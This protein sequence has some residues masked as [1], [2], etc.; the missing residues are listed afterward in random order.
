MKNI[1]FKTENLEF[2]G[3]IKYKDIEIKK[4]LINFIVGE[5]GVGKSTLFKLL[6]CSLPKS[7][8]NIYYNDIN[9]DNIDTLKLRQ[10]ISLISQDIFLFD[11]SIKYNFI[12]F[13]KYRKLPPPTDITIE[14]FLKLCCVYFNLDKDASTMSGG[15]RQRLY[16]A[17]FLSLKPKV[18]LLDEPT[19][20]L[21]SKSGSGVIKNIISYCKSNN[22]DM[23]AVSHDK[24]LTA[25]YSE[26][27]ITLEKQV[28]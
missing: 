20:A 6:N 23:V 18:I 9:T 26:N 24:K 22:I 28:I 10:E 21:D 25:E 1:L 3:F 12:E 14:K 27:T 5:S 16:I 4:K 7:G 13:Y 15:E 19:S 17:I 2:G 8:G 11:D